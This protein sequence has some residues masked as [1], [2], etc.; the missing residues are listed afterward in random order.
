MAGK[1]RF[2]EETVLDAL[3]QNF[4]TRGY[5]A[6]SIEDLER[7]TGLRRQSLYGA[8]G[9]KE[10]MYARAMDRYLQASGGPIRAAIERDDPREGIRAFIDAHVARMADPACPGGCFHAAA[11]AE[12]V[13]GSILGERTA[14]DV[15]AAAGWL[16]G[17][18]ERWREAGRLRSDRDPRPLAL[19]LIA[20]VRG[21]AVMHRA[22]GDLD[23]VREA[24]DAG[25]AAL[26]PWLHQH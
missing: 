19:Y 17:V 8:F 13:P 16:T 10:A 7:A 4:W 21:L 5:E 9:P 25:L 12:H 6:T 15:R 14:A 2:D 23:A 24:V 11:C 22:T 1:K 20:F 18:V 3:V 26:D